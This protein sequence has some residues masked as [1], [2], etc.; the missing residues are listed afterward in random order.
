MVGVLA[1]QGW[2]NSGKC[3]LASTDGSANFLSLHIKKWI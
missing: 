2:V 1:R 3:N